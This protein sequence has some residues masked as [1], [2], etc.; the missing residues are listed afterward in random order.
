MRRENWGSF[1]VVPGRTVFLSSA[2]GDI[3]EHLNCLMGVK[4]PFGAQKGGWVFSP[5][6]AVEKGLSSL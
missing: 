5:D 4:D 3:G 6:A 1:S 2:D